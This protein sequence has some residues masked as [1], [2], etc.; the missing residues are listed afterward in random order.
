MQK[1]QKT[2]KD[3]SA[4]VAEV[5]RNILGALNYYSLKTGKPVHL[6]KALSYSLSPL[7]LSICKLDGTRR[8]TVKWKLKDILLQD[9]E[10]HTNEGPQSLQEYAVVVDMIVLMNTIL[11]KSST[12]AEFAKIF[13]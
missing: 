6:K 12:H 4:K 13:V 5:N 8:Q 3:R 9:L 2:K 1:I 10:D 7:P 11:N